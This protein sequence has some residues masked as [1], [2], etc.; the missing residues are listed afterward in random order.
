MLVCAGAGK[1]G[2]GTE[3]AVLAGATTWA[4]GGWY[5]SMEWGSG[6]CIVITEAVA[7]GCVKASFFLI[8]SS[9]PVYTEKKSTP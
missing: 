6:G 7:G 2:V 9:Q 8:M 5:G 1:A 3:G 4:G